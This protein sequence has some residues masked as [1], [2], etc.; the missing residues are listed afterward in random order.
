MINSS[1]RE[2]AFEN[3]DRP[4]CKSLKGLDFSACLHR[5]P[6]TKIMNECGKPSLYCAFGADQR[7]F[8]QSTG[9]RGSKDFYRYA[10]ANVILLLQKELVIDL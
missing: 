2:T 8:I 5:S 1:E 6:K 4:G 3:V 9:S 7:V 10:T